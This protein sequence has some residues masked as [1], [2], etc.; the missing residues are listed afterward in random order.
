MKLKYQIFLSQGLLVFLSV[1]IIVLNIGTL[2]S[3]ENDANIINLSGKLRALSYKMAYLSTIITGQDEGVFNERNELIQ[4]IES[5]DRIIEGLIHGSSDLGT[6]KLV[7]QPTLEKIQSIKSIWTEKYKT[8]YLAVYSSG[9]AEPATIISQD[10]LDYVKSI[11][12]MVTTYSKYSMD[13]VVKAIYMN[14]ILILAI[15]LISSY[16]FLTAESKIKK[17][18]YALLEE[19]KEMDLIDKDFAKEINLSKKNELTAMSSYIDELLYDG[20]TK[21]YN[22]RSGLP[23]L[24]RMINSDDEAKIYSLCY[25]DINGL[26]Q[27]N[28]QLGH[29]Y[30]DDLIK[31]VVDVV[32]KQIRGDD[33]VIRLG[34]DEFLIVFQDVDVKVAENIWKRISKAYEAIN[35]SL[36]KPYIISVSHGVVGCSNKDECSV[37]T[38]I[39]IADEKMYEEKRKMKEDVEFSVVR[40]GGI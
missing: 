22:R 12:S 23:K 4:S 27:V 18:V 32:K 5:F 7:Y 24:S 34:G 2:S 38:L 15:V 20:L 19:L 21:V 31:T 37:D 25:I 28:D 13:K 33:F 14:G 10:I 16:S 8:A 40:K 39:K 11:D 36:E 1:L 3:M 26:K 17:P 35:K 30:G 29:K 6:I 9:R